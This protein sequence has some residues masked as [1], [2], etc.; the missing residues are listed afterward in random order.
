VHAPCW[1]RHHYRA[2]GCQ[3]T[4]ILIMYTLYTHNLAFAASSLVILSSPSVLIRENITNTLGSYPFIH[5]LHWLL[6]C[7]PRP[8]ISVTEA[9]AA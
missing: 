4:Y 5:S 2:Q 3:Y 7:T 9:S 6:K 8:L 1:R